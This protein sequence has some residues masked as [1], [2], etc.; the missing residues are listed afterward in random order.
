MDIVTQLVDLVLKGGATAVLIIILVV[1]GRDYLRL[2][3]QN[4]Q[5]F[6]QRDKARLALTLVRA[7]AD[8]AGAKY[9]LRQVDELVKDDA[10]LAG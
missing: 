5:I 3:K 9:D 10:E 4:A 8:A 6:A 2:R 1:L 7:A